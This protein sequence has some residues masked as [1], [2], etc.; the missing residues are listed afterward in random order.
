[1]RQ[2]VQVAAAAVAERGADDNHEHSHPNL[3]LPVGADSPLLVGLAL[4]N[5]PRPGGTVP[6][7][8]AAKLGPSFRKSCCSP[9]WTVRSATSVDRC[10][11]ASRDHVGGSPKEPSDPLNPHSSSPR[12]GLNESPATAPMRPSA[13]GVNASIPREDVGRPLSSPPQPCIGLPSN[14]STKCGVRVETPHPSLS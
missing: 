5:S 10:D 2:P 12:K 9:I 14:W 13:K 7:S 3:G 1:M 4:W 6:P 11:P 8:G